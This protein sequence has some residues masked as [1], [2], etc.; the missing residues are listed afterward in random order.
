ML[1]HLNL[2]IYNNFTHQKFVT[3]KCG[4]VEYTILINFIIV[5][6]YIILL[7]QYNNI[8]RAYYRQDASY[9]YEHVIIA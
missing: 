3:I 1:I 4:T 8:N 2:I 7:T 9:R 6:L 5:D